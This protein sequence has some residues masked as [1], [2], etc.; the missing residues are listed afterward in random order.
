LPDALTVELRDEDLPFGQRRDSAAFE[1]GGT[2]R[3]E[4]GNEDGVRLPGGRTIFHVLYAKDRPFEIKGAFRDSL[5]GVDGHARQMRDQPFEAIRKRSN[6]VK[7]TWSDESRIGLLKEAKFG[8]ED[9]HNIT[10]YLKCP[11]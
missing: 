6:L 8:E 1:S 5:V 10:Y 3:G 4:T 11:N 2:V 9:A 7:L